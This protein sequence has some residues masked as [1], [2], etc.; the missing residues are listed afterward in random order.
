[1]KNVNLSSVSQR[2]DAQHNKKEHTDQKLKHTPSCACVEY[3]ITGGPRLSVSHWTYKQYKTT[4]KTR[5]FY[6]NIN[7][8]MIHF[9]KYGIHGH[10]LVATQES[11]FFE[12][13]ALWIMCR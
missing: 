13:D 7:M 1:M 11:P 3:C 9:Y 5:L 6:S 12:K 4:V 8:S 2:N 10:D